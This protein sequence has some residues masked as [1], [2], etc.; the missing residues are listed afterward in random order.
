MSIEKFDNLD[1]RWSSS[2][3]MED[4]DDPVQSVIT[5]PPYWDLKD[6]EHD[7]QIGKSDDSYEQYLQRI[8]TV[9]ERCYSNL[10]ESGTV[11]LVVDSFVKNGDTKLL[12]YHI[13]QRAK[14]AGFVPQNAI[15]W[16]KPT[17]IGGYNDRTVVNKKEYIIFLSKRRDFNIFVD[18]DEVDEPEDPANAVEGRLNNIW[19][20]PVKRGSLSKGNILHKA[21]YPT[22]LAERLVNISTQAGDRVLDPFLGSGTTALAALRS[23]RKCVGYEINQDFE[24]EIEERLS[25]VEQQTLPLNSKTD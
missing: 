1:V 19:R 21:P 7:N 8:Q 6:Y 5:S 24:S 16:Y 14:N 11:W 13:Q 3:D 20:H 12:P 15:V 18:Q 2:E 4:F 17:A 9:L 10:N 23:G 25:S 22:S